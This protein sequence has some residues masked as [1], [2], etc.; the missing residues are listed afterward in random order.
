MRVVKDHLEHNNVSKLGHFTV[1][2][3]AHNL[4]QGQLENMGNPNR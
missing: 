3:N 4:N 1:P 2:N